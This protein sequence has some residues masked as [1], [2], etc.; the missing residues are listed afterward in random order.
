MVSAVAIVHLLIAGVIAIVHVRIA[1]AIIVGMSTVGKP[2]NGEA[3]A[4]HLPT[5]GATVH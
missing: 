5:A 2:L 1:G 4:A 3:A